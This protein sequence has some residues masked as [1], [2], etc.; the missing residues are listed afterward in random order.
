MEQTLPRLGT[1]SI[2]ERI[3][4][5]H[6]GGVFVLQREY[7]LH[8]AQLSGC[9]ILMKVNWAGHEVHLKKGRFIFVLNQAAKFYGTIL[10]VSTA[11]VS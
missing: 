10:H 11:K 2:S 8:P 7:V 3:T 9:E 5:H 4:S 1:F 6:C